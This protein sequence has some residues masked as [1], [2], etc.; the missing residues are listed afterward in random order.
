MSFTQKGECRNTGRTHLKKGHIPWNKGK[1]GI[2][3]E[4][5][6]RKIGESTKS[7]LKIY[8]HLKGKNRSEEVKQKISESLI[9]YHE[10]DIGNPGI[11]ASYWKDISERIFI[12]DKYACQECGK[13][14]FRIKGP[15]VINCHHIDYDTSNN[16]SENLITLCASCHAK[17]GFNRGDWIEYFNKKLRDKLTKGGTQ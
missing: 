15:G 7:R 12:R 6:L 16:N 11:Y 8:N 2:Y 14:L 1:T 4:D 17:T 5:Q 13:K 10:N 3:S 9:Q